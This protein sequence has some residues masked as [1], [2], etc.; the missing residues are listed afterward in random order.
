MFQV[1]TLHALPGHVWFPGPCFSIKMVTSYHISVWATPMLKGRRPVG[2]LFFNMEL[3]IPVRR[4]RY[5][6][7]GPWKPTATRVACAVGHIRAYRQSLSRKV[8]PRALPVD[9]V[10]GCWAGVTNPCYI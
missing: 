9:L 2:R 3:P 5:I 10:A 6:E 4:R 7:T 1:V 8:G